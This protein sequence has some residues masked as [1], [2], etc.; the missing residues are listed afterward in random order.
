MSICGR[1]LVSNPTFLK[2]EEETN[3]INIFF[4]KSEI[5]TKLHISINS[6]FPS[7]ALDLLTK[8]PTPKTR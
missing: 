4:K 5:N 6:M 8:I 2:Y 7:S 1:K 3:H